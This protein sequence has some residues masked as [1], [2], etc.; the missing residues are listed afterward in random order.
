MRTLFTLF[1]LVSTLNSKVPTPQFTATPQGIFV[2]PGKAVE[3]KK[4]YEPGK[5]VEFKQVE[6][7]NAGGA[8][9]DPN[10]MWWNLTPPKTLSAADFVELKKARLT[11]QTE[12]AKPAETPGPTIKK[13]DSG[14][15]PRM[16]S[17]VMG[18]AVAAL[19][20]STSQA[21]NTTADFNNQLRDAISQQGQAAR[22]RAELLLE[23]KRSATRVDRERRELMRARAQE[24][25][26]RK[27]FY[28]HTRANKI[29]HS[30]AGRSSSV[31]QRILEEDMY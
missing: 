2:A 7:A 17:G 10:V 5:V 21:N 23:K 27:E 4:I 19:G 16:G 12:S 28:R 8:A 24:K 13:T 3:E 18:G 6:G 20:S 29:K 9:T 22:E 11:L 1:F 30:L 26:E 14:T 31:K 15:G 25:R